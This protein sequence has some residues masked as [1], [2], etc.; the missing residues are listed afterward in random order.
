MSISQAAVVKS[1]RQTSDADIEKQM[2]VMFH[3]DKVKQEEGTKFSRL[4]RVVGLSAGVALSTWT[5]TAACV[6]ECV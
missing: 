1:E 2:T 4:A 3:K 6:C 5:L